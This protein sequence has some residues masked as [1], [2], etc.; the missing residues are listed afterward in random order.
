ML[1]YI[2]GYLLSKVRQVNALLVRTRGSRLVVRGMM[3]HRCLC[4]CRLLLD[5]GGLDYTRN[6]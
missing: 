3:S 5:V 1:V 2:I 4:I 6:V